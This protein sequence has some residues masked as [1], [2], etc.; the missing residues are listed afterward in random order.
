MSGGF[1]KLGRAAR[2]E[3]AEI[4]EGSDLAARIER[5]V[6]SAVPRR[7]RMS[8]RILPVFALAAAAMV[9]VVAKPGRDPQISFTIA[10]EGTGDNAAPIVAQ[11]APKLIAFSE[12]T[13]VEVA[14][15]A[16]VRV[17]KTG[18]HAAEVGLVSGRITARVKHVDVDTHWLFRAGPYTVTVTGTAFDL[19]WN[20]SAQRFAL[21]M[22]EGRVILTGGSLTAPREVRAGES[23]LLG[24]TAAAPTVAAAPPVIAEPQ[25]APPEAPPTVQPAQ[26]TIAPDAN[27]AGKLFARADA[28]ALQGDERTAVRL[29]EQLSRKYPHDALAGLASFAAGRL[30]LTQL[31]N[32]AGAL[33]ELERARRLGLPDPLAEAC[34]ARIVEALT[35]LKRRK[36]C[37]DEKARYLGK[38]RQGVHLAMVA[39]ACD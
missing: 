19:S 35:R 8:W 34:H 28:L 37:V 39:E 23:V 33:P 13:T 24:E 14:S 29:F 9:L 31:H 4:A 1:E 6:L 30:L 32:P 21:K 2:H 11:D 17:L 5:Q 36:E 38:Y 15:Q 16:E 10:G 26:P 18:T 22:L 20:A 12:G 7:S 27:A 25:S 3:L